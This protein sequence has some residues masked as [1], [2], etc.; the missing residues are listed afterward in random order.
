MLNSE[1]FATH[2]A[3]VVK[4]DQL[5]FNFV[6]DLSDEFLVIWVG[7]VFPSLKKYENVGKA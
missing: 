5:A 7:A 3:A 2:L 4:G 6:C 1:I